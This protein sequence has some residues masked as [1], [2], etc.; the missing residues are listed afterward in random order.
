VVGSWKVIW[1]PAGVARAIIN[2]NAVDLS[3]TTSTGWHG[4]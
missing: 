2:T 4:D 1:A 3:I